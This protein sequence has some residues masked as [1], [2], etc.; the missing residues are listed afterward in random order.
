MNTFERTLLRS[1]LKQE[2]TQGWDHDLR[3]TDLFREIRLACEQEFREDNKVTLDSFL[4][5][6][7]RAAGIAVKHDLPETTWKIAPDRGEDL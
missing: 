2:V 7:L 3:I 6:C 1:F 5:D 4:V